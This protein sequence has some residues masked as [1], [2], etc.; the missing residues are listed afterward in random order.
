VAAPSTST[1]ISGLVPGSNYEW[2]L[3]SNA[4]SANGFALAGAWSAIQTFSTPAPS[5]GPITGLSSTN[6]GA[7]SGQLNW[8]LV[9]GVTKYTIFYRPV[10]STT[11]LKKSNGATATSRILTGLIAGTTYEWRIDIKC[12]DG[13]TAPSA[14]QNFTTGAPGRLADATS[15]EWAFTIHPNPSNGQFTITPLAEVEGLAT[16]QLVDIAGRVIL[17]QT[18]NASEDATLVLDKQLDLGLYVLTITAADRQQFSSR[19]V[20]AN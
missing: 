5:C 15:A 9:S 3:R 4:C 11:W 18:W 20:I 16:V 2:Q 10:G 19:M 14:V 7:N 1:T 13:T 6:V 8:I 12:A 17:N